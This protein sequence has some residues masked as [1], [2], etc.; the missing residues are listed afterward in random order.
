VSRQLTLGR[1]LDTLA[2]RV[3]LAR[4]QNCRISFCSSS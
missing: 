4:Q 1:I 3:M 2:E